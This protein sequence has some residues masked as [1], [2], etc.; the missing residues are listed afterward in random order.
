MKKKLLIVLIILFTSAAMAQTKKQI[1][2]LTLGTFHFNF[3]NLDLIKTHDNDKID[4]LK[5]EYQYEIEN[6]VKRIAKFKPTII[7]IEREPNE[8][9]KFD[10]L[11]NQYLLGKYMLSRNEEEQI[12]FRIAKMMKLKKIYCV[13]SWGRDYEAISTVIEGKDSL[14]NKKF[15]NYFN[16]S[17]DTLQQYF[18]K[19]I[20]KT[21]GIRAELIRQNEENK[22]KTDLGTYLLGIFKYENN[23]NDFFG[24]DF[25]T[26]WWFNRNLRI[27]RNI[28]KINA[29]P[30]DRILVIFGAGHMNLLN[31]FFDASPEYKL[32]KIN[33]YLK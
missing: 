21:K 25:V 29:S 16:K 23:E 1:E 28:Q 13:D 26:G 5:P 32:L 14:S 33:K 27:F 4:V 17:I 11:Y 18:P 31:V 30:T 12:G 2:V 22:V 7:V 10:S 20:F 3:P 24:T 9:Q 8:Q 15:M 19:P 6:I